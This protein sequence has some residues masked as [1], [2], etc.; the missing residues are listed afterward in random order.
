[1]EEIESKSLRQSVNT[2]SGI[3]S[4]NENLQNI[5]IFFNDKEA[6][7]KFQSLFPEMEQK[8]SS[9]FQKI[10]QNPQL[11][12]ELD[13]SAKEISGLLH[14]FAVGMTSEARKETDYR[15]EKGK[16]A[17]SKLSL[18]LLL[19]VDKW[20]DSHT[21]KVAKVMRY[22]LSQVIILIRLYEKD[23]YCSWKAD[24]EQIKE[25]VDIVLN[26]SMPKCVEAMGQLKERVSKLNS[27]ISAKAKVFDQ[28]LSRRVLIISKEIEENNS[29]LVEFAQT[30]F[31]KKN[32]SNSVSE[33]GSEAKE[34]SNR[35]LSS[36]DSLLECVSKFGESIAK[37]MSYKHVEVDDIY[38]SIRNLPSLILNKKSKEVLETEVKKVIGSVKKI[39]QKIKC[40]ASEVLPKKTSNYIRLCLE[41]AKKKESMS[42]QEK[43]A[44]DLVREEILALLLKVAKVERTSR[45]DILFEKE[46]SPKLCETIQNLVLV[47]QGVFCLIKQ[48]AKF[49]RF[50]SST[51]IS[52]TSSESKYA[53]IKNIDGEEGRNKLTRSSA[54]LATNSSMLSMSQSNVL[55]SS[56]RA[57]QSVGLLSGVNSESS[58]SEDGNKNGEEDKQV[59]ESLSALV[60]PRYTRREP[61]DKKTKGKKNISFLRKK[62][63]EV[64]SDI[65][66]NI[67]PIKLEGFLSKKGKRG[68][69][70]SWKKRFF[71]QEGRKIFYYKVT[72]KP[73][74][75]K[76]NLCAHS[77]KKIDQKSS[78]KF[79][80]VH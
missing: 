69:M 8:I 71:R 70:K 24:V 20:E 38:D 73:F 12:K 55:N 76:P 75:L 77:K 33:N 37:E 52:Q 44:I 56:V 16:N 35:V 41:Q 22:V 47:E 17:I 40:E 26:E 74:S 29:K 46:I 78:G 27:S 11:A 68:V 28:D 3:F 23:V 13:C 15:V 65:N 1:M 51:E 62:A 25:L 36:V 18:L 72:T 64:N 63:E 10:F 67:N 6:T 50:S 43:Q 54:E 58:S 42:P 66:F 30:V 2:S 14:H 7:Q 80:G 79:E 19:P 21:K 39:C 9:F 61:Q 60:S 32:S 49:K 34:Y 31:E 59:T 53:T 48:V 45:D 4:T 57:N 5:N